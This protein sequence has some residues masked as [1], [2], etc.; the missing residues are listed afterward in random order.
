[1]FS[2]ELRKQIV[3]SQESENTPEILSST[4]KK[5][6]ILKA[7]SLKNFKFTRKCMINFTVTLWLIKIK[8]VCIMKQV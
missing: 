3:L 4:L 2:C 1:M 7:N 5:K 6:K 8:I